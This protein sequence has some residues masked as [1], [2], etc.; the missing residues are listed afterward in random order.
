M[1][2]TVGECFTHPST[3]WGLCRPNP[4]DDELPA[5][6]HPEEEEPVLPT[7]FHFW[8][9]DEMRARPPHAAPERDARATMSRAMSLLQCA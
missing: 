1:F 7:G 4:T 5:Q 6:E 8:S 3:Q 9:P 2:C